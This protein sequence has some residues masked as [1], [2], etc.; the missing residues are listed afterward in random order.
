[1]RVPGQPRPTGDSLGPTRCPAWA[2]L[3]APAGWAWRILSLPRPGN[4]SDVEFLCLVAPGGPRCRGSQCTS[5]LLGDLSA[6]WGE[7]GGSGLREEGPPR[8]PVGGRCATEGQEGTHDTAIW[9]RGWRPPGRAAGAQG[10]CVRPAGWEEQGARLAVRTV[11]GGWWWEPHPRGTSAGRWACVPT[12]CLEASG[13]QCASQGPAGHQSP[14][15]AHTWEHPNC[16]DAACG[17]RG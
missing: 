4:T 5:R 12:R 14:Q 7:D 6:V 10:L 11:G 17:S 15:D 2:G 16:E 1:M 9:G 13:G 8:V 3:T